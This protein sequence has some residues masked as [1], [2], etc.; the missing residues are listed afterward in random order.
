MKCLE[1][2]AATLSVA[3]AG[4]ATSLP[5]VPQRADSAL[6][7]CP[8]SPNC[9]SSDELTESNYVEPIALSVAPEQA[10][11]AVTEV[12]GEMPRT[13]II[14]RSEDYL[15]AHCRTAM[16]FVDDLELRL[17]PQHGDIA[18]RS[19]S[20]LGYSDFGVNRER[21]ESV[22]AKLI[23]R[24][25]GQPVGSESTRKK[26]RTPHTRFTDPVPQAR[27]RIDAVGPTR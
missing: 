19:S 16:G 25:V 9:V 3:L 4:C 14:V 21:V 23:E 8:A 5:K 27:R 22:R 11:A 1:F 7:A 18:I 15:H 13:K 2:I 12:V 10:W 20:Q 17:R 24:G 6:R 26:Q